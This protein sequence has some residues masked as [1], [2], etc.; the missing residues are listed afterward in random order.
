MR[1]L[2]PVLV[3]AT[4]AGCDSRPKEPPPD[5]LKGQ[6]Q[7]MEKAKA[8]EQVLQRSA[9]ERREQSDPEK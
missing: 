8:V 2:W 1:L 9:D 5:I 3:V 4:L 6:R 7:S